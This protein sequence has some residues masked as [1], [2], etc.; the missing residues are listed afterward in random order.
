MVEVA[1]V[2]RRAAIH[3]A[4][5]EPAR[6]A[7]VDALALGDAAPGELGATL[8]LPSNLLAHHLRALEAAGVVQRVRSEADRRRTYVRLVPAALAAV[9]PDTATPAISAVRVLFVCT[10]NSAR[11]QLAAAL[12]ARRSAIPAASAGTHPAKQVHR[13]AVSTARR[14]GLKLHARGTAHVRDVHQPG[15][16][17]V[18]VCDNAYE[19]L[20]RS[21]QGRPQLHWSV[22]DPVRAD[23]DDAFDNAFTEIAARIDRL[24]RAIR[25]TP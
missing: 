22:P 25:R 18:A 10:H 8:D 24:G 4:L 19:E 1:S 9:A 5:A 20:H 16:L 21:R 13:R 14:H 3:A 12:W 2:A 17:I 23:T 7:I 15:D 11:S 6:L